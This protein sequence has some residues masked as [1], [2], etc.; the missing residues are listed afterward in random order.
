MRRSTCSNWWWARSARSSANSRSSRTSPRWCSMPGCRA[1]RRRAPPLS[2]SWRTSCSRRGGNTRTQGA[3]RGAVRERARCRLRWA[4]CRASS[5]TCWRRRARWSSRSSLKVWRCWRRRSV[6]QA[7]GVHELCR[8]GFGVT[9]PPG[10]QRV[11]IESDWLDRFGR[12]LGDRGVGRGSCC[13]RR[14]G[15]RRIRNGCSSTRLCWTMRRSGCSTSR[16]PGP[17]TWCWISASPLCRTRSAMACCGLASIWRPA[18]CRTPCWSRSRPGSM[19]R[20]WMRRCP[21]ERSA[22]GLGA[23]AECS[24]WSPGPAVP[25]RRG[26]GSLRQGPAPA[27]GPRPGA[28]ARLPQRPPSRGDA[29]PLRAAGGRSGA[30][31]RG[32]ARRGD[33]AR[34]PRQAG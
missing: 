28:A 1:R 3:G 30:P 23:R 19:R 2:R 7:L 8:L 22:G 12:L 13:A 26:A 4:A 16:R 20:G 21:A 10:A 5:P 33:R 18:R 17:A 14:S 11:G 31:A 25:A 15:R 27:A 34:I 24:I 9:L 6:Q 32:A 29:P